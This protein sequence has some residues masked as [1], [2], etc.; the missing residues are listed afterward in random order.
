LNVILKA[1]LVVAL[2]L[3]GAFFVLVG[4]FFYMEKRENAHLRDMAVIVTLCNRLENWQAEHGFPAQDLSQLPRFNAVAPLP[5]DR[6]QP[7]RGLIFAYD[8]PA[9]TQD[10]DVVLL[11]FYAGSKTSFC[12][13]RKDCRPKSDVVP[14]SAW[15]EAH[16]KAS[17]Y[18][19]R[20][21]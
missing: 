8:P 11:V 20:P 15:K 4:L 5:S 12:V 21:R 3:V 17:Y 14:V 16:P 2:V 19:L 13:M 1:I 9:T 6:A 10:N 18:Y 7:R